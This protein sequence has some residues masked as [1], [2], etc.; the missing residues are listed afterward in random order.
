MYSTKKITKKISL[1]VSYIFPKFDGKWR[2]DV[3]NG[4]THL[5]L[6]PLGLTPMF[7]HYI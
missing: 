3:P 6:H 4:T 5:Y 1:H 7:G 2:C